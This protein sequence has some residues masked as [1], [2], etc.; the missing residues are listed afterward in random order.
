MLIVLCPT[1]LKR[2]TFAYFL[3]KKVDFFALFCRL[4]LLRNANFR[5]RFHGFTRILLLIS[6]PP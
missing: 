3:P 2:V 5:H 4:K 1:K 6:T